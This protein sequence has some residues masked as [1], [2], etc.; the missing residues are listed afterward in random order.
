MVPLVLTHG[1]MGRVSLEFHHNP[2]NG[3][4]KNCNPRN[5]GRLDGTIGVHRSRP[6]QQKNQKPGFLLCTLS[7]RKL[8]VKP[9]ACLNTTQKRTVRTTEN[10]ERLQG[11]QK[12]QGALSRLHGGSPNE[13]RRAVRAE[14]GPAWA[15]GRLR[16]VQGICWALEAAGAGCFCFE[17]GPWPFVC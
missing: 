3:T 13:R 10:A 6:G 4:L 17:V 14:R 2:K 7:T 12:T 11:C 16:L 15:L 1:Q 8:I 9:R 5:Q